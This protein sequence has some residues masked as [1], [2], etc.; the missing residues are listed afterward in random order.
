MNP[1]LE[2]GFAEAKSIVAN[3]NSNLTSFFSVLSS[4]RRAAM[5]VFYAF[6]RKTDDIADSSKSK[7]EKQEELQAWF[8]CIREELSGRQTNLP[9]PTALNHVVTEYKIPH[10]Y[11][12]DILKGVSRDIGDFEIETYADLRT[13]CYLVA[14][15]VG[16]ASLHIWGIK[17]DPDDYRRYAIDCGIAMQITNILRDFHEDI[18]TRRIYFPKEDYIS[19]GLQLTDTVQPINHQYWQD[20]IQFECR[21]AQD[22]YHSGLKLQ[23]FLDPAGKKILRGLIGRYWGILKKIRRNPLFVLRGRTTL[24]RFEK[25]KISLQTLTGLPPLKIKPC[26]E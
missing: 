17:G 24:S 2:E 13:Y 14:S 18:K 12:F 20:L 4:D 11:I 22:L 26:K 10:Q 7:V 16:L 9:L 23:D 5:R 25:Y 8:N 19:R 6:C 3:S 15:T 1:L 21:R